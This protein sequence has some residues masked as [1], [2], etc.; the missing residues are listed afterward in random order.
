MSMLEDFLVL[1]R[2]ISK[3]RLYASYHFTTYCDSPEGPQKGPEILPCS[4]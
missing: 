1:Q 2:N 3:I 4:E